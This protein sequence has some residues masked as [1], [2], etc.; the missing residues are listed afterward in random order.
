MRGEGCI[1]HYIYNPST[2][3]VKSHRRLHQKIKI[4]VIIDVRA[5][6]NQPSK[7]F[8]YSSNVK[9]YKRGG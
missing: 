8:H 7:M 1:H 9:S 2:S 4:K 5:C 6:I 3:S